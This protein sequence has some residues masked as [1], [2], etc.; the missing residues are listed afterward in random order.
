MKK[1]L[2]ILLILLIVGSGSIQA[3]KSNSAHPILDWYDQLFEKK[4]GELQGFTESE[5]FSVS[6][7]GKRIVTITSEEIDKN[8]SEIL[9][10]QVK[11]SVSTINDYQEDSNNLI[12]E[13]VTALSKEE[14][15]EQIDSAAVEE[16]LEEDIENILKE[17]LNNN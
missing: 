5:L 3:S 12:E 15:K 11:K 10:K 1:V 9:L 8:L 2:T 17:V 16:E 4:A 7:G 14:L 13:T 6:N